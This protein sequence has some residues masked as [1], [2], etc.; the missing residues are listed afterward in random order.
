[1]ILSALHILFENPGQTHR[2][3]HMTG[4]KTG[5][6]IVSKTFMKCQH[7]LKQGSGKSYLINAIQNLLQGKCAVTATT[8]KA[9]YSINS[10]RGITVHS[11]L[12]LPIGPRGKKDLTRQ[13][14]CTLQETLNGIDYIIIDEYS[15]LGQVTFG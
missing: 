14:L 4:T 13:N 1:M 3:Q 10:I 11:L 2:S 9:A 15:M 12:K 7:G 6:T 8:G 5:L